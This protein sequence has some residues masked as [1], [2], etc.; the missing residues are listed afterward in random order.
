MSKHNFHCTPLPLPFTRKEGKARRALTEAIVQ[1]RREN[2]R[3]TVAILLFTV[4][5]G[6]LIHMPLIK[7]AGHPNRWM[8]VQGGIENGRRDKN[9]IALTIPEELLEEIGLWVSPRTAEVL[10][11]LTPFDLPFEVPHPGSEWRGKRYWP[12]IVRA[13]S[14]IIHGRPYRLEKGKVIGVQWVTSFEEVT[15]QMR[16]NR[17]EKNEHLFPVIKLIF[18]TYGA[19]APETG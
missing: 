6:G 19:K 3:P 5:K 12:A 11:V 9:N 17:P 16:N 13:K 10:Q 14:T 8:H 1:A 18:E 2:L 7:P 4:H 15:E